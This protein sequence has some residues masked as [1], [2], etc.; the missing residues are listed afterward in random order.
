VASCVCK[1]ETID[2]ANHRHCLGSMR[3]PTEALISIHEG[4]LLLIETQG[5]K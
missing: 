5:R 1:I 2:P 3:L 4:Y